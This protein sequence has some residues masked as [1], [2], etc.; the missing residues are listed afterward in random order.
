MKIPGN[1]AELKAYVAD[2]FGKLSTE[3]QLE[4]LKLLHK[5]IQNEEI[6]KKELELE[7]KLLDEEKA[8][9]ICAIDDEEAAIQEEILEEIRRHNHI[10]V[11][12]FKDASSDPRDEDAKYVDKTMDK[13]IKDPN[14]PMVEYLDDL[15][16]QEKPES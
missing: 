6:V 5:Y 3:A 2:N 1:I 11:H 14:D 9:K 8:T 16:E 4:V 7:Q 15:E 12:M 10:D 13:A